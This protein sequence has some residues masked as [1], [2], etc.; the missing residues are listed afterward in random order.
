M[1]LT[2]NQQKYTFTPYATLSFAGCVWY[3]QSADRSTGLLDV[4]GF[5]DLRPW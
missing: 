4:Y 1:L 2:M 5:F 3:F